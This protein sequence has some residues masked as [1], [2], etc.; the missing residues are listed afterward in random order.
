MITPPVPPRKLNSQGDS[1]PPKK[2]SSQEDSIPPRK[3]SSQENLLSLSSQVPARK[4]SLQ[5]DDNGTSE[6]FTENGDN[7]DRRSRPVS[8]IVK[9]ITIQ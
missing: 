1:V 3:L 5:D 4:H 7:N 8:Y 6:V 2:L 9:I